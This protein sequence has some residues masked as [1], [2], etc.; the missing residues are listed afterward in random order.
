MSK[1]IIKIRI[2]NVSLS[3]ENEKEINAFR[4]KLAG[5]LRTNAKNIYLEKINTERVIQEFKNGL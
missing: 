1:V 3:F 2:E 5:L 4:K